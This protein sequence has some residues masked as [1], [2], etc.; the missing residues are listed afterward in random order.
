MHSDT[1]GD[2]FLEARELAACSLYCPGGTVRKDS[3]RLSRFS[4]Q[5][6]AGVCVGQRQRSA[7]NYRARGIEAPGP[8][9]GPRWI[10][11]SSDGERTAGEARR[12]AWRRG[13]KGAPATATCGKQHSLYHIEENKDDSLPVNRIP[14]DCES[15]AKLS[16]NCRERKTLH[17]FSKISE[18]LMAVKEN[19]GQP[20]FREAAMRRRNDATGLCVN[21]CECEWRKPKGWENYPHER[22]R[23]K[24]SAGVYPGHPRVVRLY[25]AYRAFYGEEPDEARASTFIRDRVALS[26]AQP[27]GQFSVAQ[28]FLAWTASASGRKAVGFM[29]LMPST[30]T[31]AMRPIWFLEDLFVDLS[32][33]RKG[34]ATNFLKHAEEFARKTGAERLTLATAHDNLA[35]QGRLP[36]ARL[37]SRRAFLVFSSP[38]S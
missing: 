7:G 26:S 21:N 27:A 20:A 28:Y 29:H 22:K 24:H 36:Q 13:R 33:R 25:N 31:L 23:C 37:C 17:I 38:A 10:V 16:N 2:R 11:Q 34:I 5:G 3:H 14:L 30:N 18:I 19:L 8:E 32:A 12:K 6:H 15:L 4:L 9:G 35:A 1:V